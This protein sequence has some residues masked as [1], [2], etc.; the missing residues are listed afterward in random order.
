MLLVSGSYIKC[1]SRHSVPD[2][3]LP[4]VSTIIKKNQ[5]SVIHNKGEKNKKNKKSKMDENN[6]MRVSYLCCEGGEGDK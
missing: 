1:P 3:A 6:K 5:Y 4:L 2:C